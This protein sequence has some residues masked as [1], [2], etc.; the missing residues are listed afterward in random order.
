MVKYI[1][2]LHVND[3]FNI[4]IMRIEAYLTGLLPRDDD[5]ID[6]FKRW[7]RGEISKEVFMEAKYK[8]IKFWI[9]L[10]S[11]LDF[12]YIHDP[13]CTWEDLYRPFTNI[14]GVDPGPLSRYF[15]NNFLFRKLVINSIIDRIDNIFNGYLSYNF[16]PTNRK[17][18]ISIPG[19]YSLYKSIIS[20]LKPDDLINIVINIVVSALKELYS[21]GYSLVDLFEP[22]I[23]YDKFLDEN[24]LFQ[25]YAPIRKLGIKYNIYTFFGSI[26]GRE[27]ILSRLGAEA[28]S[29]DIYETNIDNIRV[30]FDRVIIG[31]LNAR[32]TLL[33]NFD[34]I[35][36]V[37]KKIYKRGIINTIILS[38]N[39]DLEF[40]PFKYAV[41]KADYL[42]QIKRRLML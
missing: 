1:I 7:E 19:P 18:K 12:E 8:I 17:W 36:N 28:V 42:A 24:L 33:E 27:N 31:I 3:N 30:P 22:W 34:F 13:Q 29:I 40:L 38:T 21:K 35:E 5:T 4:W 32:N 10:Q 6:I 15:E 2:I 41:D 16:M 26:A 9:D 14:S 39:C 37:V 23:V 20:N 11:N 25:L